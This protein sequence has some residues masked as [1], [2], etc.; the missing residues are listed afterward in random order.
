MLDLP[1]GFSY[2]VIT[3]A[4]D[5]LVGHAGIVPGRPDAMGAFAVSRKGLM[6]VQ[7][8]E[9]SGPGSTN[10]VAAPDHTYDPSAFGG[11]TT[12]S[13]TDGNRLVDEYVSLAGTFSNCA[14][15]I[16]PWSTWLTCEETEQKKNA[17]Y[18][19]D[20]GWVFEVD[21]FV[22]D[23]N[24]NPMPLTGLGRFPHEAA[25]VDP[26][27]GQVYLT[28]DGSGPNGLLYRFTPDS[29]PRV[30]GD[31]RGTGLLEAMYVPGVLD[32]S[33]YTEPGT[34]LPV[35]WQ[36]VPDPLAATLSTRKQ[37]NYRSGATTISG[38]GGDAT[39]SRKFEG[40]WWGDGKANIVCSFAR[41][42]DGST[43]EHDGQVWSLDPQTNT[44]RLE[45]RFARATDPDTQFDGPDN[46]TVSPYGGFFLAEDGEGTQ[47][48]LAVD[49]D[50]ETS[51]FATNRLSGSEFT[52]VVFAPDGK[53][54]FC[55]IQ[56]E[57]LTFAIS[58]P[59]A[60]LHRDTVG[61]H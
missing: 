3:R 28:E 43:A 30:Y 57:G 21:P 46:I 17:T 55:N 26:A 41:L 5:P 61:P 23:N 38:P 27:T 44:L 7:N 51:I 56:D 25:I 42:G 37:F 32:L 31:L 40:L 29:R 12:L 36:P 22:D 19:K 15:G 49:A 54:L 14:G 10:A 8:H 59:F 2:R 4:G 1:A 47:H 58:G 45:V 35:T 6:L 60:R 24:R 50:R 18:T 13:L 20:H 53:T 39:R 33:P 9:Q 34:E 16:T 52:G 11:T 48:L